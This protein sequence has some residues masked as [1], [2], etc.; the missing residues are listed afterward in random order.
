LIPFRV[1]YVMTRLSPLLLI[2]VIPGYFVNPSNPALRLTA[3][4][5]LIA[6][7]VLGLLGAILGGFLL[8]GKLR[9]ICPYCGR[10]G[11]PGASTRGR[12]HLDC[13]SC[14]IIRGSGHLGLKVESDGESD[15]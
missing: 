5:A 8:L 7:G 11:M 9:M 10:P 1:W 13:G 4:V 6:G 3:N 12:M 2:P 14:G 15:P